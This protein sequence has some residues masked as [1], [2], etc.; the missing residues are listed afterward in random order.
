MSQRDAIIQLHCAGKTNPEIIKLLKAP[1]ST[2]W[3]VVK[4]YQD[5]GTTSDRPRCGRPRTAR[6]PA[7]IK[8]I[9][10]RIR[11]NPKRSMRKMAKSLDMDEKSV[12]TIVKWDL[13]LSPFKMTNR[14][15]LTDLQKQKRLDRS[16]IL[17]NAMKDGTQAGEI[18]FSDEKM[19]TVEAK[20]N[21]QN[22][23]ILAKSADSI[24]PSVKT[25]FRRQKPAS[26]M[27]WAAVSESWR[28]PLIF[29]KEGAKINA[30]SYIEN[31][32]TPGQV[33]MK[34]QFFFFFF[35]S[36]HQKQFK[37][38][39]FTFQQDGAP[40]HTAKKTQDWCERHFPAFWRK[41]LWPPSS[42]DLNPL[43]FCVWSILEKEACATA[44]D[45]TETLK[46]TL[47]RQWAKIPQETFR[48]AVKSFRGRLERVIAANGGHIEK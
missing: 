16:K 13:K 23:R 8:C 34:K 33:E 27:V 26:V 24:P 29:V 43:D 28:S 41:E 22:D 39:P 40:S 3:K 10:E 1:R 5:L 4:R 15:Q 46:K 7:K 9:K 48:A 36:S 42:P 47:E 6:T 20:F 44:H 35:V 18:V 31:I 38:R 17:L 2:V 12:R 30:K 14:Q 25:V 11:R 19:F 21:S 37:D 45:S 32:L